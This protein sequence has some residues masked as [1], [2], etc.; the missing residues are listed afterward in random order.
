MMGC[1]TAQAPLANPIATSSRGPSGGAH[2]Q[3]LPLLGGS[4]VAISN[5]YKL[6]VPYYG[7]ELCMVTL[8][9]NLICDY[10]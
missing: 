1:S 6:L 2:R 4:W 3:T 10:P 7:F 9:I 5:G 8:L